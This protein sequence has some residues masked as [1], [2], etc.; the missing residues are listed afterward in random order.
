MNRND[1]CPERLNNFAVTV[2]DNPTGADNPICVANSGDVR[3]KVK[4]SNL[5]QAPLLGRYVHVRLYGSMR[6]L[7]MCEIMVYKSECY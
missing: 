2:G 6:Y 4:I 3:N 5:C 1:C 7:S